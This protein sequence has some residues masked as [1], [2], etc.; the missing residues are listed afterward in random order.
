MR[1]T[2]RARA[3]VWSPAPGTAPPTAGTRESPR[4]EEPRPPHWRTDPGL[5]ANPALAAPEA[6]GERTAS[7]GPP[8]SAPSTPNSSAPARPDP[9]GRRGQPCSKRRLGTAQRA[10][11]CQGSSGRRVS[12]AL[13]PKPAPTR[14]SAAALTLAQHPAPTWEAKT[15]AIPSATSP[16]RW[17]T[18]PTRRRGL[19][20]S[21]GV[22]KRRTELSVV[23]QVPEWCWGGWVSRFLPP[24]EEAYGVGC[25]PWM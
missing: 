10:A 22:R 17:T 2:Q 14:P 6:S 24:E 3:G 18:F 1:F 7:C 4:R 9:R 11:G 8:V 5:C 19:C 25:A 16:E 21:A 20:T 13:A 15:E 12:L 23:A